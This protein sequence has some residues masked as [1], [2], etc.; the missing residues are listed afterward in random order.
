MKLSPAVWF[1]VFATCGVKPI[2]ARNWA[3]IFSETIGDD[4][5]SKGPA[6]V[7]D[8]TANVIH[9][10]AGLSRLEE[11]L[12]YSAKRIRE[13]GAQYGEGSR[14]GR[15][16]ATADYLEHKPEALAEVIYGG[17]FGNVNPGDGWLYRGRGLGMI[18]FHDNYQRVGDIVGQDL[19]HVP[20]LAAQP[21][22]ALG[23]F[24]A[25]WEDK[26]PDEYIGNEAL[27]RRVVQGGKL[28]LEEV[29][30]YAANVRAT[31]EELA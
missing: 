15:A 10:S 11:N 28:G 7:P 14:W 5:F 12:S 20:D 22:Y 3:T 21:H 31:I 1:A 2:A 25:W 26:V 6:E 18:T 8:F 17:R 9:E 16:A 29:T 19:V 4:S 23:I 24:L 13:L 30:R 27:V